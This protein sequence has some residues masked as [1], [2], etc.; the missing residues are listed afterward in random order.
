MVV[1]GMI[2]GRSLTPLNSS[3]TLRA[4]RRRETVRRGDD[5]SRRKVQNVRGDSSAAPVGFL[6]T[7]APH[8]E[9]D[10]D[11]RVQEAIALVFCK[12]GELGTVR[13]TLSWLLE[14]GLQLPARSVA[15]EITWRSS[16]AVSLG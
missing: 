1:M 15:G 5:N 4:V 10:P 11:R 8:F 2:I 3:R 14:H 16:Q 6:K 9:K 13:Q 7:D 12:F